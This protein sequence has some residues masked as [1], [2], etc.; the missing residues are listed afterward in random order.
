MSD[1][2][3]RWFPSWLTPKYL[4]DPDRYLAAAAERRT[5]DAEGKP[6]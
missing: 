4:I 3:D 2:D 1:T 6:L 5:T